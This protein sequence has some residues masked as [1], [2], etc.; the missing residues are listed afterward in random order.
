M[1]TFDVL[2]GQM[3]L[4]DLVLPVCL[5]PGVD[6]RLLNFDRFLSTMARCFRLLGLV[7]L[8]VELTIILHIVILV[9][10]LTVGCPSLL[11]IFRLFLGSTIAGVCSMLLGLWCILFF[12]FLLV[13]LVDQLDVLLLLLIMGNG[14][15]LPLLAF[16]QDIADLFSEVKIHRVVLNETLNRVSAIVDL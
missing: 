10:R 13:L 4:A 8:L 7:L 11:L 12:L 9:I 16:E 2:S 6:E 14:L 15:F 5:Q 3:L 1:A